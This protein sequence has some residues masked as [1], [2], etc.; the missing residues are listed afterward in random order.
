MRLIAVGIIFYIW[1][2]ERRCGAGELGEERIGRR[3]GA[4]GMAGKYQKRNPSSRALEA[5]AEYL[6][7]EIDYNTTMWKIA[8]R[9]S[10]W[11]VHFNEY[12]QKLS[13]VFDKSKAKVNFAMIGACDGTSDNT[14]RELFLPNDHWRGLFVGQII[15]VV[16]FR[17][18]AL[19]IFGFVVLLIEPMG[20][21]VR[22]LIK[23]LADRNVTQRSLVI[24][25]AATSK[26]KSP[27]IVVERPLYGN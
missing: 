18:F 5:W 3:K 13:K 21:N 9:S 15:I 25:A 17:F 12:A 19:I 1:C 27:T 8:H 24:R 4:N 26:C 6:D 22:D 16:L 23:F 7:P 10:T 20:I 11:S 2:I 14:I